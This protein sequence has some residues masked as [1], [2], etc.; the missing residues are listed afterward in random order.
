MYEYGEVPRVLPPSD[1][2]SRRWSNTLTL[3]FAR[4]YLGVS[5]LIKSKL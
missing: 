5:N 2:A 1:K 3:L 4:M